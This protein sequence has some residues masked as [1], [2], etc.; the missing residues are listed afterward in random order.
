MPTMAY[1][2]HRLRDFKGHLKP[3]VA[4]MCKVKAEHADTPPMVAKG[5]GAGCTDAGVV[6]HLMVLAGHVGHQG[7]EVAVAHGHGLVG[8][9]G[10]ES[11]VLAVRSHRYP[12]H[13]VH[14]HGGP[15]GQHHR[16]Q[17][18]S[19]LLH[20]FRKTAQ[21]YILFQKKPNR[22]EQI[23]RHP[24]RRTPTPPPISIIRAAQP[25]GYAALLFCL[26]AYQSKWPNAQGLVK[27]RKFSFGLRKSF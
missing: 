17:Y 21:R 1:G 14:V 4:G 9:R 11:S 7:H 23:C 22:K 24:N 16:H 3:V 10:A 12:L 8:R 5:G 6:L 26:R 15:E 27:L 13:G 2:L 18:S 19:S 20:H 25:P